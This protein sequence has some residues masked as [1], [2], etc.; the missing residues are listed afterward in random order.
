MKTLQLIN[1]ISANSDL[2]KDVDLFYLD[3][4]LGK[5]GLWLQD[6]SLPSRFNGVD[7][8]QYEV[9]VRNKSKTIALTNIDYFKN[10]VETNNLCLLSDGTEFGLT[11][12]NTWDF[13]EKDS[14]SYY[15]FTSTLTLVV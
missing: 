1:F 14:E 13:L 5:A 11:I 6:S 10:W 7:K 12:D 9:Y 8:T 2:T 4:P 3:I 15:V